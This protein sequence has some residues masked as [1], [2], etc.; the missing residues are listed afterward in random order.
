MSF[1]KNRAKLVVDDSRKVMF[2]DVAGVEG[3]ERRAYGDH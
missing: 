3:G 1:G 2:A